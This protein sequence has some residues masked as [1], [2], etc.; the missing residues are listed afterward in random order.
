MVFKRWNI[1][2]NGFSTMRSFNL[3][4]GH[5][6]HYDDPVDRTQFRPDSEQ[7]RAFH[8]TGA[9]SN[10]TPVYDDDNNMPSDLIVA[11]RSGK[12]D[13]AEISQIM[14]SKSKKVQE[15]LKSIQLETLDK[16]TDSKGSDQKDTVE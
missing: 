10:T 6:E 5:N 8:M 3:R 16:S 12:L 15:D 13:K 11:M 2:P 1:Q 14:Q 7:V 9:G 4:T